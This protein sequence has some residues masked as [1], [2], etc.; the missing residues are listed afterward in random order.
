MNS[1]CLPGQ[2]HDGL[3]NIARFDTNFMTPYPYSPPRSH[4]SMDSGV[5][6]PSHNASNQQN[7]TDDS[8]SFF[9]YNGSQQPCFTGQP[10]NTP[11]SFHNVQPMASAFTITYPTDI[12]V[13]NSLSEMG[14]S[15]AQLKIV[16]EPKTI[17]RFRY[18][19]E[20]QGPHGMIQAKH[21]NKNQ[22]VFPTVALENFDGSGEVMIRCTL[23][24]Y[25]NENNEEVDFLHPHK[26]IM[27]TG[28]VDKSNLDPHY[29]KVTKQNDFT[30]VFQGL[31]IIQTK[32][33]Q[34]K[35]VF[36]EKMREERQFETQ[37]CITADEDRVI[38]ERIDELLKKKININQVRLGYTAF[39]RN[40]LNNTWDRLCGPIFSSVIN[41]KKSGKV[42]DLKICRMSALTSEADGNQEIFMFVSKVDKHT[43]KVRFYET[44]DGDPDGEIEWSADGKFSPSDVHHQ[45]GIVLKTPPYK[46]RYIEKSVKVFVQ[47]CR[48]SDGETSEAM[49]FIYKPNSQNRA[50]RKRYDIPNIPTAVENYESNANFQQQ[51]AGTQFGQS[52]Y[53]AQQFFAGGGCSSNNNND[54]QDEAELN[55][56]LRIVTSELCSDK[57][58]ESDLIKY[59]LGSADME[60]AID[61]AVPG[62]VVQQTELISLL[63]KLKMILTLFE[64]NSDEEKIRDMMLT[65]IEGAEEREENQLIE[66]IEYGTMNEIKELVLILV[67]Y[68]LLGALKA[69]NATDQ[70]AV[71]LA[72]SL[73][74]INL[75]RVLVKC[76]VSVNEPDAFGM[77]PLHIAVTENSAEMTQELLK[78]DGIELNALDDKGKSAL[79][80]SVESN[81]LEIVK[82]LINAG[83]D[84]MVRNPT[85]GFTCLHTAI[86]NS[87]IE[88]E[89]IYCLI[90]ANQKLLS[91]KPNN[92]VTVLGMAHA[93]KLPQDVIDHLLAV[94]DA[95]SGGDEEAEEGEE[96]F[97]EQCLKKLCE[98]FDEHDNWQVWIMRMDLAVN[99]A[100][101]AASP[102]PSRALLQHLLSDKK[103]N[104]QDFIELFDLLDD[105]E[106]DGALIAIDEMM[107][108]KFSK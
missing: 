29:L 27:R 17:F 2:S 56:L 103:R 104:L 80:L 7:L 48:S 57:L 31:G 68:K 42:G 82:L 5:E 61:A 60:L 46:D 16:E 100:E 9:D 25:K 3:Y 23:H 102:S 24:Q 4:L 64:E 43:I 32:K 51:S 62:K 94:Y 58:A 78:V 19:T 35:E 40:E 96:V 89:L 65:V 91:A 83:A 85:S 77:T 36:Q 90:E 95:C 6:S 75:L 28:D 18:E 107:V 55:V 66:V 98:L 79:H 74:N 37:R 33:D 30:A 92:G 63:D 34:M 50:K 108:R 99:A 53:G 59:C 88:R 67:K 71:H 10:I 44:K 39:V 41:N 54:Q 87:L 22:K 73:G 76:G 1:F 97:D 106:R 49:E 13:L 26:L 105:D 84:V 81:N 14:R 11:Q 20:M 38:Q 52:G 72:V 101:W 12:S 45:F 93:N 15:Q 86:N 47:L 69:K 8:Q 70:N 21:H